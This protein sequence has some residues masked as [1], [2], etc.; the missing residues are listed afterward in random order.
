[1]TIYYNYLVDNIQVYDGDTIR[2]DI[3]LGFGIWARNQKLR[4][5]GINTPELNSKDPQEKVKA[6]E[7]RDYIRDLLKNNDQTAVR[8]IHDKKGKYGRWLAIL[9]I[10]G[11]NINEMLIELGM[12]KTYQG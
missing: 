7:V 3:D 9:F 11:I 5:A 2:A 1:M 12:A 10:D 6:Y 8:T 4:L